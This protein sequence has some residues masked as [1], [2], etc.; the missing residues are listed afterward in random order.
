MRYGGNTCCVEV[1]CGDDVL[2]F[3]AGSGI[4]PLGYRIVDEPGL[5]PIDIFFSHCHIDHILGLP[6]FAPLFEPGRKIRLWAGHLEPAMHL[7]EAVRQYLSHPLF[8]IGIDM[9]T[10]AI[11]FRDF[12]AGDHFEP[13]PGIAMRSVPL[14]HPGGATGYRVEF[15]GRAMVYLTDLELGDIR[16]D[17]AVMELAKGADLLIMDATYTAD[18]LPGH[19][20]WG[21]SSWQQAVEFANIVGAGQLCL[22][23]HDPEHDDTMMDR[24]AA[25]AKAAFANAVVAREGLVIE[26]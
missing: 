7:S 20:G 22:F 4:R 2:I 14:N 25:E 9:T 26:L 21:H 8:P 24:I 6:F 23:H 10:A 13:R 19:V 16:A 17:L 11:E 5:A 12:V 15:G 1:R 18:E 3:D